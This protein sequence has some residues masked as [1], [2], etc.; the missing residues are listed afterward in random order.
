[1]KFDGATWKLDGMDEPGVYP[2]RSLNQTW[3]LDSKRSSPVLGIKRQQFPLTPAYARTAHASQGK[4][5]TA[6]LLD[7]AVDKR[8]DATFG[9]VAASRVRSR[10]DCLILRPC[11]RWLSTGECPKAPSCCY[12]S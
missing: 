10:Y 2:I 5:L 6:V 9:A 1:M 7:L 11:P 12:R 4:T 8:V 3:F